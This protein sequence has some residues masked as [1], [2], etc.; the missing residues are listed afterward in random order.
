[1]TGLLYILL[2]YEYYNSDSIGG[3]SAPISEIMSGLKRSAKDKRSDLLPCA[4][5]RK[6]KSERSLRLSFALLGVRAEPGHYSGLK[7]SAKDKRSDFLPCGI[8]RKVKSERALR[9]S[10]ALLGVRVEPGHYL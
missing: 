3:L 1:M 9:L 8:V 4:I 6:V 2:D 7:R 10:F 5:V